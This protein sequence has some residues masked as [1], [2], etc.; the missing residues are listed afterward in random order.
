MHK[1]KNQ[2]ITS[3]YKYLNKYLVFMSL[4]ILPTYPQF[5]YPH[6]LL[7]LMIVEVILK[8]RVHL[9][10]KKQNNKDFNTSL[11]HDVSFSYLIQDPRQDRIFLRG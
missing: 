4:L 2:I 7:L 8:Q 11:W 3:R 5:L 9:Q 6:L 10:A 1:F